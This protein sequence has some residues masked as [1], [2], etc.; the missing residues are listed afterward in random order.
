MATLLLCDEDFPEVMLATPGD[1]GLDRDEAGF[2][3]LKPVTL[4][5]FLAIDFK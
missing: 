1:L 3:I 5:G 4:P 2:K